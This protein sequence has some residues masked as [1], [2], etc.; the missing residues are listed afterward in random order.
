MPTPN[1]SATTSPRTREA[2][3]NLLQR[4]EPAAGADGFEGLVAHA[5]A[6]LSGFT[7]RL[8]R[9]GSQFGRDGA[10][11]AGQFSIAMEAKRYR[12]SVPL[13]ELVGKSALAAFELADDVDVWVLAATVEVSEP[14][15]RR[16]Q[17]T[18]T[19]RYHP[20]DAGLG[21]DWNS[22]L[23][24]APRGDAGQRAHLGKV[25]ALTPQPRCVRAGLNDILAEPDFDRSL[26]A[27]E[28]CLSPSTLGLDALRCANGRWCGRHFSDRRLAQTQFS[29]FLAPLDG[30]ERGSRGPELWLR[31]ARRSSRRA[32]TPR[33]TRSSRCSGARDPGRR[34]PSRTGGSQT[35]AGQYCYSRSVGWLTTSW[36]AT[37]RSTCWHAWRRIKTERE[38]SAR[39]TA[40]VVNSSGGRSPMLGAT[41]SSCSS[42]G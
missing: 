13:Q 17:E 19:W 8:A 9:S 33:A 29:Q 31:L 30:A 22:T 21:E 32:W 23:G 39:S 40:G 27:L 10:T 2:L 18:S 42:T 5:L 4:W 16:L 15:Q 3:K 7:F 26:E 20:P 35:R 24:D 38:T 11:T 6:N 34:G 25:P 41:A 28:A 36:P 37:S 12:K 1:T 14:T